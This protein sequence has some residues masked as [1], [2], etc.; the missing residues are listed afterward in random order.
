MQNNCV[1]DEPKILFDVFLLAEQLSSDHEE[2]PLTPPRPPTQ[3]SSTQP[4]PSTTACYALL[5]AGGC[6]RALPAPA[7]RSAYR[8]RILQ[9]TDDDEEEEVQERGRVT[10][11]RSYGRCPLRT[12]YI[13]HTPQRQRGTEAGGCCRVWWGAAGRGWRAGRCCS[14][15]ARPVRRRCR[16]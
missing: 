2:D 13:T 5:R 1:V 14:L 7:I 6:S 15:S 8:A 4:R 10:E 9:C 11:A 16:R 3:F 12:R